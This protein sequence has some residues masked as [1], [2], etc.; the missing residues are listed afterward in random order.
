MD[1][2]ELTENEKRCIIIAIATGYVDDGK[3]TFSEEEVTKDAS[4]YV[5]HL[6]VE[7]GLLKLVVDGRIMIKM[8]D[9]EAHFKLIEK[10]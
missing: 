4:D 5:T 2:Y 1:R 7:L 10:E 8:T 6:E 9:G 3:T